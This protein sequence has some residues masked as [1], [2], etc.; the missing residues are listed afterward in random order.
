MSIVALSLAYVMLS[1]TKKKHL[2]DNQE[3]SYIVAVYT[4][5]V[6]T[7]KNFG[8]YAIVKCVGRDFVILLLKILNLYN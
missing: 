4:P 7:E 2:M 6:R 3:L 1:S 5:C 8:F